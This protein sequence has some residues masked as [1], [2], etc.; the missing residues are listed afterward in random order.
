[1]QLSYGSCVHCT[2]KC[3]DGCASMENIL[4]RIAKV[5]HLYYANICMVLTCAPLGPK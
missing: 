5:L 2:E 3:L 4:E 1:M